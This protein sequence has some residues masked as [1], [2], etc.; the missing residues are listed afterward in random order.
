MKRL[1]FT[2]PIGLISTAAWATCPTSPSNWDLASCNIG[3]TN[4]CTLSGTTWTCDVSGSNQS[5]HVYVVSSFSSG[6][7]YEAWGDK[8]GALF[9]CQLTDDDVTKIVI[10]GSSYNDVLA[11]SFGGVS[12]NLADIN[13]VG[14][15]GEIYGNGGDDQLSGS[16]IPG[17]VESLYGD[18]G[19]DL[20]RGY[21]GDDYLDGGAEDDVMLG[22]AGN[23]TMFGGTGNDEMVGGMGDDAMDGG[24][25][26]DRMGGGDDN[27]TMDGGLGDDVMCGDNEAGAPY[28]VLIDGDSDIG[29]DILWAASAND[30]VT[31]MNTSTKWDNTA[32]DLG[33]CASN[34]TI[35]SKPAACP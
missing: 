2:L 13:A 5:A 33:S 6:S 28:D 20:L 9:C 8:N 23:D 27:D 11:F 14:L 19:A 4:V 26:H 29:I 21:Q 34:P 30:S 22:H 31:C 3:G 15:T 35:T 17:F 10:D 18:A 32:N 16:D 1:L 24:N 12:H 7:D 25:G